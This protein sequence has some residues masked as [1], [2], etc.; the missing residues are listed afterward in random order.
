MI[1]ELGNIVKDLE[2]IVNDAKYIRFADFK[3]TYRL[4]IEEINKIK[5]MNN[6]TRFLLKP[7][8]SVSSMLRVKDW[9]CKEAWN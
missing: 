5:V 4:V 8:K 7:C 9:E 2:N 3:G 1:N 6:Y